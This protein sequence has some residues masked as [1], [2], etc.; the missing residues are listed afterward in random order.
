MGCVTASSEALVFM[1]AWL[2]LTTEQVDFAGAFGTTGQLYP[3]SFRQ[4]RADWHTSARIE[5]AVHET[6]MGDLNVAQDE[7]EEAHFD[8][9]VWQKY[10]LTARAVV[11][12]GSPRNKGRKDVVLKKDNPEDWSRA[13]EYL[14]DKRMYLPVPALAGSDFRTVAS[15]QRENFLAA[16]NMT[17]AQHGLA[18]RVLTYMGD[19]CAKEGTPE[20]L[21]VAWYKLR[22]AGMTPRENCISTYMYA[23]SLSDSP[24]SGE[25]AAF[26]DLLF[27]PNEKTITLRIKSMIA[28]QD[29]AGAKKLLAS[30][31]VCLLC[32]VEKH[33]RHM[34]PRHIQ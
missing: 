34:V 5:C 32:A 31:P 19:K 7:Q 9:V 22:E 33:A 2:S 15:V 28:E 21:Q 23:M 18:M 16:A 20:P 1:V 25:V 6:S 12:M 4:S 26:H 10:E 8:P 11:D 30:F 29:A 27:Q 3:P 14:L 13:I 17:M 24:A